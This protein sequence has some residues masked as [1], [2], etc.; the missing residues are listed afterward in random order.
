MALFLQGNYFSFA[1][2]KRNFD[3]YE[4]LTTGDSSLSA[5]IQGIVG[6][7]LGYLDLAETYF[8]QT[9]LIDIRDL[10]GNVKDGVHTASMA[11][12]WMS[13][14]YGL[15]GMR[16]SGNILSFSPRLPSG[17]DEISF[18]INYSGCLLYVN[19]TKD[20]V[21]YKLLEG[22][23]LVFYNYYDEIHIVFEENLIISLLPKLKVVL[24]DITLEGS[25]DDLIFKIEE[26]GIK[27][28][29][30]TERTGIVP[31]PD[32]EL[33]LNAAE[34]LKIRRWDCFCITS[35]SESEKA[36]ISAEIAYIKVENIE[37]CTL[38]DII[39]RHEDFFVNW[40]NGI[41]F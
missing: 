33:F 9:T 35:G 2:K 27:C 34:G 6:S 37:E 3:Y 25:I 22:N 10:N 8:R 38:P 30:L 12:S 29:V 14:I 39:K 13:V 16:D 1:E 28:V 21:T 5:C 23:E 31:P 7:E 15:A 40:N 4:K 11:G 41:S 32:P 19:I 36:L 24:I 26:E 17:L 18:K 20:T